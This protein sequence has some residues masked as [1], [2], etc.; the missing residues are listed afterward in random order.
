MQGEPSNLKRKR[1]AD[2]EGEEDDG[3]SDVS[4]DDSVRPVEGGSNYSDEELALLPYS[5][6]FLPH[7][8]FVSA[9]LRC[10]ADNYTGSPVAQ[11]V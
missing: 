10:T 5:M 2:E 9:L 6:S 4:S 8:I 11:Q 1:S 7:F 3:W